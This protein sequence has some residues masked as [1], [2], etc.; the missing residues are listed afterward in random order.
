MNHPEVFATVVPAAV[1]VAAGMLAAHWSPRRR[2]WGD[3]VRYS[4]GVGWIGVWTV[5]TWLF[6]QWITSAAILLVAAFYVGIAGAATTF[7]HLFDEAKGSAARAKSA[8]RE[9][10]E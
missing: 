9:L 7:A 8:E 5:I 2:H 10:D 4:F 3:L 6:H 1:A